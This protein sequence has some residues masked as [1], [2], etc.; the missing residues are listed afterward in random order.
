[1]TQSA[2]PP[3]K[4]GREAEEE[5]FH[6]ERGRPGGRGVGP[7]RLGSQERGTLRTTGQGRISAPESGPASSGHRVSAS[8]PVTPGKSPLGF[9]CEQ[10]EAVREQGRAPFQLRHSGPSC[11]LCPRARPSHEQTPLNCPGQQLLAARRPSGRPPGLPKRPAGRVPPRGRGESRFPCR[12]TL[13]CLCLRSPAV[14]GDRRCGRA[15]GGEGEAD[16]GQ[17]REGD[18]SK[19]SQW[20]EVQAITV[21]SAKSPLPPPAPSLVQ[22]FP[23]PRGLLAVNQ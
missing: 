1:M 9:P 11:S 19:C 15:G 6:R 3:A 10:Q 14:G 17:V 13:L 5:R 18:S 4:R 2:A 8:R 16:Q 21:P 7:T 22:S 23:G 12:K 20:F